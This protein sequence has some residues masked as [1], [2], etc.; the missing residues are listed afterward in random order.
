MEGD[1][2]TQN[3]NLWLPEGRDNEGIWDD[4]VHTAIFKMDNQQGHFVQ[5][6]ELCLMLC[7]NL[8]RNGVQGENGYMYMYG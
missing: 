1:S 4:H 7:S 3:M 6:M 8:D 2:Q 5:H